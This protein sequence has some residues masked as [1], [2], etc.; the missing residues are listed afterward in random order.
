MRRQLGRRRFVRSVAV[1][2]LAGGLAGCSGIDTGGDEPTEEQ[3]TDTTASEPTVT[4]TATAEPTPAARTVTG[5]VG[6]ASG[7][8]SSPVTGTDGT[9]TFSL[10]VSDE[11]AG[12]SAESVAVSYPQGFDL[13]SAASLDGVSVQIGAQN[14]VLTEATVTGVAARNSGR[15]LRIS[16]DGSTTFPEDGVV[17]TTYGPVAQPSLRGEYLVTGTANGTVSDTGVLTLS[18]TTPTITSTFDTSIEGWRVAGDAQ[19]G[20]AFPY[21]ESSGG[22]PGGHLRVEDDVQ[23]GVWY[24]V[25]SPA[26][27]E[28]KS[29]YY[30]GRLTFDLQQSSLSSQFTDVAD[31][32]LVGGSGVELVYDFGGDSSHPETSWTGYDLTLD[33]S[34]DWRAGAHDGPAATASQV[35]STLG[36]LTELRIRGEYVSGAD[37][38]RL[39][40]PALVPP[41]SGE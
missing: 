32:V 40:N 23:G 24:W 4:A 10:A 38:G 26:F 14:T 39:D 19:G 1:A 29:A 20:S 27:L 2:G 36:D 11:L 41:G 6:D 22:N 21:H 9:H 37:T 31:V 28:D 7:V 3:S 5:P 30:G 18:D 15:E 17:V 34:D 16:L 12:Q 35:Q 13:A 8:T 33:E 25:A